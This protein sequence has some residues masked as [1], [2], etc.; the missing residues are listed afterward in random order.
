MS[1][2]KKGCNM[3]NGMDEYGNE[4]VTLR[5]EYDGAQHNNYKMEVNE[6]IW[7]EFGENEIAWFGRHLNNFLRQIGYIRRHD[8]IFMEDVTEA[9]ADMLGEYLKNVIRGNGVADE[10]EEDE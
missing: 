3:F 1:L 8:V 9:E 6:P 4:V 2:V 10:E 5:M 7:E